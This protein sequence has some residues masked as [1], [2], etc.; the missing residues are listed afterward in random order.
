MTHLNVRLISL[1]RPGYGA[2]DPKNF[3]SVAAWVEDLEHA[4]KAL[5]LDRFSLLGFSGGGVFALAGAAALPTRVDR[6][7]V[8]G[9][10]A[11]FTG[12]EFLD[13]MAVQNQEIWMLGRA[14]YGV[15][16]EALAPIASD[17]SAL[18][19]QLLENLPNADAAVFTDPAPRANFSRAVIEGLRQGVGGT[20]RDLA[21]IAAPWGFDLSQVTQPV[22]IWHGDADRNIP[23]NH[24]VRLSESLPRARA[25]IRSCQGHY[26]VHAST[27]FE[28]VL[29]S[30][31][32]I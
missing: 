11:P 20:A 31:T 7:A 9:C 6:V 1:E 2:S 5:G 21:L 27:S 14:G 10:P 25:H 24:C 13:G 16:A 32:T 18:A 8:V 12:P 26:E 29:R 28:Q 4:A 22:D 17:P 23:V 15:L 3:E 19:E 30:L